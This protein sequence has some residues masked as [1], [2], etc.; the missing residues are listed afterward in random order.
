MNE[1]LK[2]IL[3]RN[4]RFG[5]TEMKLNELG[6]DIGNKTLSEVLNEVKSK[7]VK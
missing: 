1:E 4:N 2:T 5:E 7:Y 6:I 3:T